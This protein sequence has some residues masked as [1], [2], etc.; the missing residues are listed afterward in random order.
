MN[1][2]KEWPEEESHTFF[3]ISECE[4]PKERQKIH[5]FGRWIR[6]ILPMIY[7]KL[8]NAESDVAGGDRSYLLAVTKD[9][10]SSSVILVRN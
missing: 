7:V 4:K 1:D 3:C 5:S 6:T 9:Q 10:R 2:D 8:E